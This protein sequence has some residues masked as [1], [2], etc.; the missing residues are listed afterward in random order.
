MTDL[1]SLPSLPTLPVAGQQPAGPVL[2]IDLGTTNTLVAVW[3]DGV[4]RVLTGPDG[5]ALI[6]SVVSFPTGRPPVVGAAALER[7][8]L[9]PQRTV[10]SAKRL[11]GKGLADLE[12]ES[13]SLPYQLVEAG[14][15]DLVL[16]DLGDGRQVSP[17]EVSAQILG[18]AR[19]LAVDALGC[20]PEDLSRAVVTV[21]AYF[22]DAQRQ[23]TRE[24]AKLAGLKVLRILNEPT[25]A[26]LAYGL[27][28]KGASRVLVYDLGGGTFDAS[29]LQLDDGVYRVLAT[30]GD[31]YLGGDD[32][33][34][35]LMELAVG[36]LRKKTDRDVFA[37]PA[38]RTALRMAAERCKKELSASP[39]ADLVYH[40]PA[41]GVALRERVSRGQFEQ[42]IRPLVARTL[43]RCEQVLRD[44]GVDNDGLDQVVLVGGSTRVPLVR[45]MVAEFFGR[46]P[47]TGLDPDQVVAL[48]AAAQA[49]VLS[50]AT[51]GMLL[52]D[53]TPLSLGIETMGG[54]VSKLI[55]R[56]APIP[57]RA[58]EGYT[59]YVDGQ[60]AVK[61]HVLQGEREMAADC[62]SLGEFELRGIP[63]MPA[64]LPKVAVE[65][66]L[67]ADG[68]L[69][70]RA[71]EERSGVA[72]EIEI[73]PKHGLTDA[74]V[75]G[76]LK[77]AWDH[78]EGD[79]Q[80]RRSTDLHTQLQTVRRAVE[81]NLGLA[82][83][84]LDGKA[85]ERLQEALEDAVAAAAEE[86]PD[87]LK[88]VLDELE[89]AAYPLAE[90]LM[91]QV[92]AGSIADRR[93]DELLGK[94]D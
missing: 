71:K 68:L 11:L 45:E 69:R 8:R 82:R 93:I 76:M 65:F 34:R 29:L 58:I 23:A 62:R 1:P 39:E 35:E 49:G 4:P 13:A 61:L 66:T 27:D 44:A 57:A 12:R 80:R 63:P 79:M 25:A 64:G 51:A 55:H 86:A 10:H 18:A 41:A 20:G 36:L 89:E 73:Q 48:G 6:P 70:V 31:T 72:A 40:D 75:E 33:D 50:G 67:D 54:A 19:R 3:Q 43:E 37:D 16:I 5:E 22:D 46:Q 7:A 88:G 60:T 47:H 56:N 87:R 74:D 9:D 24:A 94:Q 26:A 28:R 85:L 42:L 14:Q 17:V 38:A 21:P 78:A 52:L 81:K 59:T 15:R 92:A 84:T 83:Q 2:G 77:A 90:A 53:V 32:L 91:H 30:A